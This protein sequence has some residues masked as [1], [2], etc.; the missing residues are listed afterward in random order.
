MWSPGHLKVGTSL[1]AGGPQASP[2]EAS[3]LAGGPNRLGQPFR[4]APP[5]ASNF[6]GLGH[7]ARSSTPRSCALPWRRSAAGHPTPIQLTWFNERGQ[8]IQ[9]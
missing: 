8:S 4:A 6:P 3:P 1:S 2:I 5:A 7:R 9:D